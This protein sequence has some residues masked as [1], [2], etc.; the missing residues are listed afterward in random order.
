MS[1]V[2]SILLRLNHSDLGLHALLEE[3]R[4]GEEPVFDEANDWYDWT[5]VDPDQLDRAEEI[6][7]ALER[8]AQTGL[9]RQFPG[10]AV[11][12]ECSADATPGLEV[13]PEAAEKLVQTFVDAQR[14]IWIEQAWAAPHDNEGEAS[15]GDA[16]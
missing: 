16:A 3:N 12:V 13:E 14:A 7:Q 2:R 9:E 1:R 11:E 5:R 15:G 4:D 10:A 6:I 8:V